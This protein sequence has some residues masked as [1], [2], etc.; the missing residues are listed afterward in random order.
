MGGRTAGCSLPAPVLVKGSSTG[1]QGGEDGSGEVLH[2]YLFCLQ[3]TISE[4]HE[5]L[6]AGLSQI[7]RLEKTSFCL[8]FL[9]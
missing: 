7:P 9:S 3:A 8:S 1:A 6:L 5:R 2:G 4:S